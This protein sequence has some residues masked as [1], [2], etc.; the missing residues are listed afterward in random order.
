MSVLYRF[1]YAEKAFYPVA[2][3]CRAVKIARS[4]YYAWCDGEAAR[5]ARREADEALAHEITVLR[6][7]S[8]G[9]MP[10]WGAWAVG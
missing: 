1:I 2:L 7:A 8:R 5:Q 10:G 4:S 6:K 9:S 3:L